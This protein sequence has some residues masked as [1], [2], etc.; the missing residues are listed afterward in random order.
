LL[1]IVAPL[2]FLLSALLAWRAGDLGALFKAC[3]LVICFILLWL[4]V[5]NVLS[6]RL[7]T[8]DEPI[9]KRRESG[10]LKQFPI[11]VAASF[12]IG[13]LVNF[14]LI[15]RVLAAR[16]LT[17]RLGEAFIPGVLIV[18][19]CL[20][21]KTG[22][23]ARALIARSS[24]FWTRAREAGG[25][26]VGPGGAPAAAQRRGRT[27]WTREETPAGWAACREGGTE[28]GPG[29]RPG[30]RSGSRAHLS[31]A[32]SRGDQVGW[33]G[34]RSGGASQLGAL[35]EARDSAAPAGAKGWLVDS[36]CQIASASL[37]ARSTWATFGPR[38]RPSRVLV[39]R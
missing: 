39:R 9:R 10:S 12:V 27:T 29:W 13:Y 4:G 7:P 30:G 26:R 14:M 19:S 17:E 1:C 35:Y 28:R 37:R 32:A 16:A 21:M 31:I 34:L 11:A 22:A 2:G 25:R 5:G 15:W 24:S 33:E 36:M 8:R 3:A 23:G 20:S 18:L 6:I 38:W